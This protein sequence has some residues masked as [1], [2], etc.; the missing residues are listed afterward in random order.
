MPAHPAELYPGDIK[1]VLLSEEQIQSKTAELG[2][3]IGADYQ[4]AAARQDLLLITVLKGAVM[5]VTDL[6]R[7]IPLPTQ[8]EFMAVSSYGSSTSSSGVVRILKDLDRDIH[9][10]DVLIV[11]DIVD[12]GLTLSWLLRNLATRHPRSLQVCTL[13]RKPEAVR[14]DV[15]ITYVGFDIPNEFVVGYGLDYAERYRD[16]PYIG[17][18]DPKV[19]EDP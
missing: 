7:V 11:E 9:D 10:R 1:S 13:L 16:L 3:Q 5:F 2:A 4:D 14:A 8:L 17:T 19:Y 15:D 12:S 18:L 6:A